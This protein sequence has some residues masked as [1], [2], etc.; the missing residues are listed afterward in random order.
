MD[1]VLTDYLEWHV[2]LF[3]TKHLKVFHN[4]CQKVV[5]SVKTF[6]PFTP[7]SG[8]L[9]QTTEKTDVY[10]MRPFKSPP[11]SHNFEASHRP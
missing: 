10:Y 1:I 3:T 4:W 2:H 5:N 9:F 11:I 6:L 7:Y 8:F